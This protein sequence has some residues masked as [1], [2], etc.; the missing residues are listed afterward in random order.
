MDTTVKS[1]APTGSGTA[2]G[3]QPFL[4]DACVVLAAPAVALSRPAGAMRSGADGFFRGDRRFLSRLVAD[5]EGVPLAPVRTG[6][7]DASTAAFRTVL[8][9]VGEQ[10]ADPAVTLRHTRTVHADGLRESFEFHNAG[11]LDVTVPLALSLDA[12]FAAM[13]DVKAGRRAA[14]PGVRRADDA[15][16]WHWQEWESRL[17]STPAPDSVDDEGGTAVRAHY[18][19]TLPPGGRARVDLDCAAVDRDGFPFAPA[20]T[21][22]VPWSRPRLRVPDHRFP[23]LLDRSLDDLAGLLLTDP[24]HPQDTFLA[25]GAP[26]F[27]TLFGRDALWAAR[28]LLPLGTDLAAGTLRTLARRQ[29]T[30]DI[31][32]TEEQPGKILH[33]V[34]RTSQLLDEGTTLPPL[35]YGTVDAGPLWVALLH[36]AWRWGLAETEVEALLPHAERVLAWMAEH[37]DADGDGLLEYVDSTGKGLANQGWKDSGDSMRW[38]SGRLAVAPVALS[39]VQA[40]AHEAAVGGAALL[41]AFGRPDADRWEEWAARLRDRFRDRF[42]LDDARGPYCAA[43]LDGQKRPLDTDTSSHGHLLGTGLLT[44][45]ESGLLARRLASPELDC[46]FGLR[47]LETGATGFNPL[48]YHIGS[49]WPHDTAIAV[50]GL[51]RAGFPDEADSLVRGL[52]AASETF[53]ARLP[54][55]FA[56]HGSGV[57]TGPAPYPAACRPQAWAAASSVHLLRALLGLEADVPG[58]TLRVADSVAESWRPLRAEGLS[59]AGHALSVAVDVGGGVRAETAAPVSAASRRG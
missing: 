49:V 58:G 23:R 51:A 5:V 3:L 27:L 42:W 10:T 28:M 48:G 50:H 21:R 6:H 39:E 14:P 57:D 15:L 36:D 9:G 11:P 18:R 52:L 1:Q 55:L 47:T 46:G 37:G 22:R 17:T 35:Y 43:A 56:G 13:D 53:D 44:E 40:Y 30:R 38:R 59:V 8:R 12:D 7:S 2:S 24:E 34:R 20:P 41:R 4:H 33:E 25:A 16:R 45:E 26:W 54:E 29:G 31:P 32:A 19:L